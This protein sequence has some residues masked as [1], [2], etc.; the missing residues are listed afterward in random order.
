MS[1]LH[2]PAVCLV[3][4]RRRCVGRTLESV[5]QAAVDGG[6]TLVQLRE[7]DL[8][9]EELLP[10][11]E[12]LRKITGGR[13]L[14]IVNGDVDVAAKCGADGV[15]LPE[16]A[17]PVLSARDV[18]GGGLL[19]G[20]SVHG[21]ES[22]LEAEKEGADYLVVGT[23]FPSRSH[24]GGELAGL[25]L[26]RRLRTLSTP[27]LAIGGLKS[28]NAVQAISAGAS[29]VAAITPITEN[30]DPGRAAADLVAAT[31]RAWEARRIPGS[32]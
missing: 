18:V 14:L 30:P 13:A 19:V 20:R 9:S 10:L 3:T 15:H 6:V 2:L 28:A 12:A 25:T 26:L 1:T 8:P 31:Q 27:Y 4:D 24:P 21:V 17:M 22:A 11:A 16:Q 32:A 5:V 23:I 29:G 7:K